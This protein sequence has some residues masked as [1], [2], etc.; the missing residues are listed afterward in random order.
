MPNLYKLLITMLENIRVEKEF[1]E[2]ILLPSYFFKF[3]DEYYEFI[4][5]SNFDYLSLL[6]EMYG[7]VGFECRVLLRSCGGVVVE[8]GWWGWI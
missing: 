4:H 2:A 1:D 3:G 6:Y 7:L 8:V 5:S